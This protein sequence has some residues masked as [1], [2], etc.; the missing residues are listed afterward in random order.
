[1][2]KRRFIMEQH[3]ELI[4]YLIPLALISGFILFPALLW[5]GKQDETKNK[6]H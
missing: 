6:K 2:N 1:M 5:L 4:G 3:S